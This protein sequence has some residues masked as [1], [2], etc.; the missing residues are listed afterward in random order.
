VSTVRPR[1]TDTLSERVRRLRRSSRT[2][3]MALRYVVTGGT[4]ALVYLGLGL[5]LSGPLGVPIQIAIP[6]A[7]ALSL[8]LNYML[9][10]HFVFGHSESFALSG[11]AQFVRYAQIGVAQYAFT[12]GATALLPGPL[13]VSEQVVYVVAALTAPVITFLLLRLVVFHAE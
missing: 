3:V 11:R 1:R 7:F 4:V 5:L 2:H 6:V 13:G 8:M 10:R 12:A 9:Q